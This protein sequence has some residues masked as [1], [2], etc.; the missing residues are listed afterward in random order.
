MRIFVFS[1]DSDFWT[2]EYEKFRYEKP[3][4]TLRKF[5]EKRAI[6]ASCAC[7]IKCGPIVVFRVMYPPCLLNQ[8]SLQLSSR[9]IQI[10]NLVVLAGP[11]E[12]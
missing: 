3:I 10:L 7:N 6:E 1:V 4:T 5:L 9:T 12:D 2:F 8:L 11:L